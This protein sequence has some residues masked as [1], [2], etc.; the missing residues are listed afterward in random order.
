MRRYVALVLGLGT[1]IAVT[2]VGIAAAAGGEGPITIQLPSIELGVNVGFS[3]KMLSKSEQS[4]V[5]VAAEGA[6]KELDGSPPLALRE[7][8]M[9]V[10]KAVQFHAEGIPAC[11]R[12]ELGE[13]VETATALKR[14]GPALIGEGE[15]TVQVDFPETEPV[16]IPSKLL[17]FK[18]GEK[19]GK[20]T[21]FIH[22]YFTNPISAAV[23]T[24]V[25]IAKHPNGPFGTRAVAKIPPI[26]GGVGSMT[27]F[28]FEISRQVEVEGKRY[29]PVSAACV[30]G[31]LR[32]LNLGK[33][34]DGEK[35]ETEVI[36]A[37]TARK[38]GTDA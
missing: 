10:D 33:F 4:P 5:S 14:C 29:N 13:T 8:T 15:A 20:T 18:G 38:G 9:E 2:A 34:E 26:A 31:K 22:S 36:R 24:R 17:V 27:K 1:L 11:K 12:S 37:C 21:L 28:N 30:D 32:V 7:L 35:A 25:T 6:I 16:N 19:D 23:V 3:P